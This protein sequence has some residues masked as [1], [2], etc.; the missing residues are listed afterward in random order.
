MVRE[1]GGLFSEPLFDISTIVNKHTGS[2]Y[3]DDV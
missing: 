1:V 2:F 3:F